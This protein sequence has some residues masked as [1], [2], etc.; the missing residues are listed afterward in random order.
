[1][2]LDQITVLHQILSP[3]QAQIDQAQ[4][5]LQRDDLPSLLKL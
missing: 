3:L 4:D 1:M 5:G 2:E